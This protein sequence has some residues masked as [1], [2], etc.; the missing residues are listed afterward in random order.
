MA[1]LDTDGLHVDLV[2]L[3]KD[4]HA[5]CGDAGLDLLVYCTVRTGTQQARIWRKGRSGATIE[6]TITEARTYQGDILDGRKEPKP[7]DIERARAAEQG[8]PDLSVFPPTA[9]DP[10]S[11]A[12]FLNWSLGCILTVG[13]QTGAT[14][15]TNAMPGYSA[16]QYGVAIDAIVLQDDKALWDEPDVVQEMGEHGEAAGLEWAGRWKKRFRE[17]VHFQLPDWRKR[18]REGTA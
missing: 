18:I 17:R 5:R 7:S 4:F 9:T 11:V 2:P 1:K 12:R 14:V 16:H 15:R 3:V 6:E 8:I 10:I 13:P